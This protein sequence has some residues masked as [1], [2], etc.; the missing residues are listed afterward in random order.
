M[1]EED[2]F[3][4]DVPGN[5]RQKRHT[6]SVQA[7]YASDSEDQRSDLDDSDRESDKKSDDDMFASEDEA[8]TE[9]KEQFDMEKFEQE[10]GLGKYDT[11]QVP[12]GETVDEGQTEEVME[13][14]NNI[15]EFDEENTYRARPKQEVAVEA[16]NLREEAEAGLFD[17]NMNYVRKPTSDSENEEDAWMLGLK[18]SDIAKAREAQLR[19]ANHETKHHSLLVEQ[20][21]PGVIEVLEPA[22]TPM[23]ALARLAPA[24]ARKR[25]NRNKTK[26][27]STENAFSQDDSLRKQTV[28]DL[29]DS[30]EQL[31]EKG[32]SNVYD[33]T[34][35]ELMRLFK[36]KTGED[37]APLGKKRMREP[38]DQ[39]EIQWEFRWLDD[40]DTAWH[41]PHS[42]YE[43]HYWK[44]NYFENNVEVRRVGE[45]EARH[46]SV[47]EFPCDEEG[48]REE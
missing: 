25:G 5:K 22:E 21:L 46:V 27:R 42:T 3:K 23:E 44:G 48:E 13:Y 24:K 7:G 8:E 18:S 37:F 40:D 12:V 32:V 38:D 28:L 29:T 34:R 4:E 26:S 17:K 19:R 16:F 35:E 30:C 11:E 45:T 15:E 39:S 36:R 20:L 9:K 31:L 33:A 10:Q 43:M 41:G 1:V 2:Y 6:R 14:Y 47:V